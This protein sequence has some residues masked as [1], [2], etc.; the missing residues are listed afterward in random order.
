MQCVE[1][2]QQ[3]RCCV[4]ASLTSSSLLVRIS[5]SDQQTCDDVACDSTGCDHD[6]GCGWN[7]NWS[8]TCDGSGCDYLGD[9]N[10]DDDCD[11][12]NN[13]YWRCN[14]S[15]CD[16]CETSV[17][18]DCDWGDESCQYECNF[19]AGC[20]WNAACDRSSCESEASFSICDGDE[21]CDLTAGCDNDEDW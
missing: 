19:D 4:R 20:G 16:N 11:W 6:E 15:S 14:D 21:D 13:Q 17:W 1:R 3:A 8:Y 2:C 9:C 10:Y 12:I 18:S 5:P 7:D